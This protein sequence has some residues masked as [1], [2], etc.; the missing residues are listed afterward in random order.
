MHRDA[1]ATSNAVFRVGEEGPEKNNAPMKMKRKFSFFYSWREDAER[2]TNFP[3]RS[4]FS[5]VCFAPVEGNPDLSRTLYAG[6]S[7]DGSEG[8]VQRAT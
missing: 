8:G 3:I 1:A 5:E 4:L 6:T 2:L 7:A